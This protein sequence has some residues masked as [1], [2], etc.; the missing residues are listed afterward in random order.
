MID[1]V[2]KNFKKIKLQRKYSVISLRAINSFMKVSTKSASVN[3]HYPYSMSL[4]AQE[5]LET[6]IINYQIEIPKR[7]TKFFSLKRNNFL[8]IKFFTQKWDIKKENFRINLIFK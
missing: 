5:L 3:I 7:I 8:N 4:V 1:L 2:D 6:I